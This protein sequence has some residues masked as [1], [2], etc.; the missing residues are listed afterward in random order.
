MLD[1]CRAV[2]QGVSRDLLR[3]VENGSWPA[4]L[5]PWILVL[6]PPC[7]AAQQVIWLG[8]VLVVYPDDS[9]RVTPAV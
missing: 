2:P 5:D 6:A 9:G 3:S 8:A 7:I 1:L 4:D